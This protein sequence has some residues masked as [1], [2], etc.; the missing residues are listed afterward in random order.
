MA[1][2][3]KTIFENLVGESF[4]YIKK[5][6]E[7]DDEFVVDEKMVVREDGKIIENENNELDI[8]KNKFLY[9]INIINKENYNIN[10]NDFNQEI[11]K[12]ISKVLNVDKENIYILSNNK[13][14]FINNFIKTTNFVKLSPKQI[15]IKYPTLKLLYEYKLLID[16]FFRIK[17]KLSKESFNFKYNF[18]TPNSSLISRRGKEI[19]YPP[20]G[21]L[22]IG[23]NVNNKF[24]KIDNSWLDKKDISSEW[25]I[26]YYIFKNLNSNEI[27]NQLRN[28]IMNNDFYLNE[29]F[30]IKMDYFN[31]RINDKKIKRI[32]YLLLLK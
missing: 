26:G 18:I 11:L 4:D 19:Y 27:I 2:C 28:I 14:A 10:N 23:L 29:N 20:Y 6:G 25:A 22:G 32:L 16:G 12:G 7:I 24:G 5:M 15:R 13:K 17:C 3:I 8:I 9:I 30:Q 31:K 1:D 21:W